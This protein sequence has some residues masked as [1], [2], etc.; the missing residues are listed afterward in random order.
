M[1][2]LD[3]ATEGLAPIIRKQITSDLKAEGLSLLVIEKSIASLLPLADR[4]FVIETGKIVWSGDSNALRRDKTQ[5]DGG[6]QGVD[7]PFG[8]GPQQRLEF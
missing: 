8:S 6:P 3:E 1:I 5:A 4:H 7:C 2:V